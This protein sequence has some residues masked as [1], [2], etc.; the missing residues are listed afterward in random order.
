MDKAQSSKQ[1]LKSSKR[2]RAAIANAIRE[3]MDGKMKMELWA[4]IQQRFKLLRPKNVESEEVWVKFVEDTLSAHF[5]EKSSK[6]SKMRTNQKLLH[7]MGRKGYPRMAHEMRKKNPDLKGLRTRVWTCG[8]L[9]KDGKPIN[10]AVADTLRRIEECSAS[11]SDTPAEDSIRDDAVAR[12][13]GPECHGRTQAQRMGA[14]E[15]KVEALLKLSQQSVDDRN[16]N[17]ITPQSHQASTTPMIN[18]RCQLLHWY[19][20]E[21]EEVVAE[22]K[23]A[24]TDPSAKPWEVLL[25]GQRAVLGYFESEQCYVYILHDDLS[26]A[27]IQPD[28]PLAISVHHLP[29]RQLS[30]ASTIQSS[31][32]P[33]RSLPPPTRSISLPPNLVPTQRMLGYNAYKQVEV[34]VEALKVWW[35]KRNVPID[36]EE[37]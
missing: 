34:E 14:L 26:F 5:T 3:T 17:V 33:T 32:T 13:L 8:H 31:F 7:T 23:I 28:P 25:L 10:E 35:A 27:R 30:H 19:M 29:V 36:E 6:F 20:F 21:D 16:S 4:F 2:R 37:Q 11:I 24:A 12:I 22:G 18:A 15:E 1:S 9:R